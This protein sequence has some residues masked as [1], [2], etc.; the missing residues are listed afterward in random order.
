MEK[1][2]LNQKEVDTTQGMRLSR[3]DDGNYVLLFNEWV[4]E[5]TPAVW[6]RL[7]ML[8][9]VAFCYVCGHTWRIRTKTPVACPHCGSQKWQVPTTRVGP[10]KRPSVSPEKINSMLDD[11]LKEL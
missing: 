2:R 7:R 10:G 4:M 6:E 1:N 8:T 5:Y 3:S 9:Q 11:F